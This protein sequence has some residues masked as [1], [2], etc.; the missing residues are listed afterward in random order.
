[1]AAFWRDTAKR[2]WT[3][4]SVIVTALVAFARTSKIEAR[5]APGDFN[6]WGIATG[7][8]SVEVVV[9]VPEEKN[10][11][12]DSCYGTLSGPDQERHFSC[13]DHGG[14]S[15]TVTLKGLEPAT[16]Y[17][18]TVTFVNELDDCDEAATTKSIVIKTQAE[19]TEPDPS[20]TTRPNQ[21]EAAAGMVFL[22]T[23]K[24]VILSM[25]SLVVLL[26]R[27][28]NNYCMNRG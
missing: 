23:P 18:C 8:R 6:L 19:P 22:P 27:H 24:V 10:G 26:Q 20:C 17:N 14:K 3:A 13:D 25:S 9:F 7:A 15:S 12:L 28:F 5:A 21:A 16:E 11:L 2:R 4:K 1:M